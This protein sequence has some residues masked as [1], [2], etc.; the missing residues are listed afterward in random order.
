MRQKNKGQ[1]KILA[2]VILF[3]IIILAVF[4]W[5]LFFTPLTKWRAGEVEFT[6]FVEEVQTNYTSNDFSAKN[7]FLNLNGLF[8]RLSGRRVLNNVIRLN[9]GMLGR[10]LSTDNSALSEYLVN[11]SARL[12]VEVG[13]PFLYVQAP[14]KENCDQLLP[15]GI[16]YNVQ[17][18][19]DQLLSTLE[20]G[21]VDFID[22]RPLVSDTV[23]KVNQYFYRTDHHWNSDA[24]FVAFQTIVAQL[25]E[26][27]PDANIDLS[28]TDPDL[29]ERHELEH[30]FMGS[31]GKRVG[32]YFGGTDSLIW[33]TPLFETEQSCAIPKH[34]QLF[35]GDYETANIRS[36]YIEEKDYF[37][38]DA[39]CVNIG[40]DYPLDQHRNAQAPSDLKVL[41][42][43][44]SFTKTVEGFMS[45]MF[46]EVDV[47]DPRHWTDELTVA[48]YIQWTQPDIVIMLTN[49][50]SW[51]NKY[52][53]QLGEFSA[54][55]VEC[56]LVEERSIE[57]SAK[58]DTNNYV[59][60]DLKGNTIYQV[61]FHHVEVIEGD[62]DGFSLGV[63]N[64]TSKSM[65][66]NA[67]FDR[68]YY[69]ST[70]RYVWTFKT[71]DTSDSLKL[72]FYA[73]L[74]GKTNGI[75]AIYQNVVLSEMQ[76][77]VT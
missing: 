39:Y 4:N 60:I 33:Y 54:A 61:T 40:G 52:Y 74:H 23:E 11:F 49:P 48:E 71:P 59:G 25:A 26:Q 24:G 45:A 68:T 73:G 35:T 7:Q 32:Q 55:E 57:V 44:D 75:G 72:L 50:S 53:R 17:E 36:K 43:K 42:I 41:M 5:K 56:L 67:V 20:A 76:V 58:D 64:A 21:G 1:G 19:T 51:T 14:C 16:T 10:T 47:V 27:F 15:S 22:M 30:W 9:N 63:Y 34:K 6:S 62:P 12:D 3:S 46:K 69:E 77:A 37:G 38:Y 29:W 28:Y 66:A 8:A 2:V 18:A 65:L 31:L 13:I 70:G